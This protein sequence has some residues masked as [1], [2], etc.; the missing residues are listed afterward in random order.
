MRVAIFS[1]VHGNSTALDAVLTDAAAA[2]VDEFWVVGDLAAHGPHPARTLERLRSLPHARFVRG[3]TDR[4]VVAGDLP[5]IVRTGNAEL[6]LSAATSFAWTRGAI[7]ATGAYD[8]LAARPVESRT[9]LPDGTRVML[10]HAAPGTDDGPG[11]HASMTDRELEECLAGAETD[12]VF[13]GHTHKPLDRTV[14]GVRVI[15]LGSVSLPMTDELRAQWTLL[16]A[17]ENSHVIERK[18]T[19]YDIDAVCAEI[20]AV[21]HP[22]ADWLTAKLRR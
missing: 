15:N 3:N 18:F 10:V 1:D 14:S 11:I 19:P 13:V 16:S 5:E 8:G 20:E 7:T 22:S 21:H 4:Y 9:R 17:D 12:L 6:L 2:G